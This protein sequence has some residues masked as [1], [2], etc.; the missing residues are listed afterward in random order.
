MEIH[1]IRYFAAV[2]R[3][4]NFTRAARSCFVSQPSLSQQI[5][6]LEDEIGQPLFQRL[7]R[8]A[9]L[10]E[11]G[12][13]FQ[14]RARRILREIDNARRE[15]ADMAETGGRLVVG[16]IPTVV[17]FLMPGVLEELRNSDPRLRIELREEILGRIVD[18]VHSGELDLAVTSRL[19]PSTELQ[20]EPLITEPI[21]LVL[22]VG[23]PLA[24]QVDIS[25]ESL[26]DEPFVFL[27]ETSSLGHQ[28]TRFLMDVDFDPNVVSKCSQVRTVKNLVA[29]GLGLSFLPAIAAESQGE[30]NLVYR[31]LRGISPYRELGIVRHPQRYL[32]TGARRFCETVKAHAAT[33]RNSTLE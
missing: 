16:G 4:G 24:D 32:G 20:F 8:R 26:R 27:G 21:W 6:K 18:S 15:L 33:L 25:I 22:P 13:R 31:R 29:H 2:A 28:V 7:G 17:P 3:E 19:G 9:V 5:L 30:S 12:E 14:A 1:Q 11:A 23:H 10:T